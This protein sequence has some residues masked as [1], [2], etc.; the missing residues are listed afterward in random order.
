MQR[1]VG[2]WRAGNDLAISHD[3]R[4]YPLIAVVDAFRKTR[5]TDVRDRNYAFL[6]LVVGGSRLEVDYAETLARLLVRATNTFK[7]DADEIVPLLLALKLDAKSL[8]LES[9]IRGSEL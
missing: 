6:A 5:C 8:F 7:L 3:S 1:L 4:Q 9:G 2:D